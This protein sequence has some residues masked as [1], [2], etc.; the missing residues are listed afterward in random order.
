MG[1]DFRELMESQWQAGKFVCV[2]SDS[3]YSKIP[4]GVKKGWSA[5]EWSTVFAFTSAIIDD[6]GDVAGFL[7]QISHS[8]NHKTEMDS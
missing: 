5:L 8:T 7:S 3:D 4:E 1:R 2:G 6:T